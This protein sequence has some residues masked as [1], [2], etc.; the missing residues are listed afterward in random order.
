MRK[1]GFGA[2]EWRKWLPATIALAIAAAFLLALFLH[3]LYLSKE[4]DKAEYI[5]DKNRLLDARIDATVSSLSRFSEYIYKNYLSA[6]WIGEILAKAARDGERI[7]DEARGELYRRLFPWFQTL[8]TY[9]FNQVAFYLPDNTVFLRMHSPSFYGDNLTY[10]QETVRRVNSTHL[11]ASAFEL[12]S[13]SIGYRFVYPVTSTSS[14]VGSAEVSFSISAFLRIL[15]E[16]D[17]SGYVFLIDKNKIESKVLQEYRDG[18]IQSEFSEKYVFD[19]NVSPEIAYRGVFKQNAQMIESLIA[20]DTDSGIFCDYDGRGLLVLVKHLRNLK[21]E[22]EACIISV[23]D[24]DI[25]PSY[26]INF[27]SILI[28]AV[29]VFVLLVAFTIILVS[30]R[31]KLK[32]LSTTDSLTAL[33]NRSVAVKTLTSELL[34]T[35]RYKHPFSILMIDLDDFKTINDRFGHAEGD[36]VLKNFASLLRRSL[37]SIDL[38]ARW[39]GEEFI[40]ILPELSHS[41]AM[42]AAVKIC[43]LT[44]S[45]SISSHTS[46]T[47]SVGCS[48]AREGDT[49]DSLTVRADN[50][51]YDAKRR[52]KNRAVDADIAESSDGPALS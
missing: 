19:R 43:E 39:G 5:D 21:G 31:D 9:D 44:A 26:D 22:T 51:L 20:R 30:E 49:I 18:F 15:R 27:R 4:S 10:V 3:S 41:A 28:L 45:S 6:Q 40:V 25:Y 52:G 12:G 48:Q 16:I 23:S 47:V 24:D 13:V 34:R 29:T 2:R 32:R 7:K 11:P 1:V 46:V 36:V 50:A 14:Y 38:P 37:R 35:N 8:V 33:P 42:A 17:N